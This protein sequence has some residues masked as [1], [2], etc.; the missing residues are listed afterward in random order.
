MTYNMQVSQNIIEKASQHP[1]KKDISVLLQTAGTWKIWA[2]CDWNL[3]ESSSSGSLLCQDMI[4]MAKDL[5][6]LQ[7]GL[8]VAFQKK[9]RL[10]F[11]RIHVTRSFITGFP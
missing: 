5:R 7:V 6:H 9:G 4:E 8:G 3:F 2:E 10:W 1:V 11:A